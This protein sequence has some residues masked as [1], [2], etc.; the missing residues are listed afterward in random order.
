MVWKFPAAIYWV[1]RVQKQNW[2]LSSK[3]S[4]KQTA[5][6]WQSISMY[7]T[8]SNKQMSRPLRWFPVSYNHGVCCR[9]SFYPLL[10]SQRSVGKKRKKKERKKINTV[11]PKHSNIVIITTTRLEGLFNTFSLK[12]WPTRIGLKLDWG[13]TVVKEAT[14]W[15]FLGF[16]YTAPN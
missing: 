6:S 12:K 5:F 11:K 10:W 16:W 14:A 4:Q 2:K 7:M 13:R 8:N 3:E 15:R 1:P 9:H